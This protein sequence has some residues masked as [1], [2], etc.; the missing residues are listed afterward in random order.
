M[1]LLLHASLP[2][3]M[4]LDKQKE[5]NKYMLEKVKHFLHGRVESAPD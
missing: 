5:L 3:N 1:L 4:V 2:P